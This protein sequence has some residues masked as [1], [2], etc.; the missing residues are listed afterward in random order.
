MQVILYMHESGNP[1]V[2]YPSVQAS[3]SMSMS[4]IANK[5][6][7]VG[8][9]LKILNEDELPA[10]PQDEWGFPESYFDSVIGGE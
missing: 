1:A 2:F 9:K 4:E 7:S 6:F 5:A 8:T 10:T 3:E